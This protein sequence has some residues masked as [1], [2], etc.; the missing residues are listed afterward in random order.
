MIDVRA[1][2]VEVTG[3]RDG[4]MLDRALGALIGGAIGDAL[5][6]PTQTLS[7]AEIAASFG[8]VTGFLAPRPGHPVSHGLIAGAVTDDTEQTLLLA[9]ALLRPG[10]FDPAAW[11]QDL[12]GWEAAVKARGLHDLLG[13]S[14]KRALLALIDGAPLGEAG[15]F[16]DTN[17]A[18]MRIAP[19]GI[20]V[21]PA[22][23]GGLLDQVEA[24]ARVTHNTGAAIAA[25]AAVAAAI[26]AA[27]D[28]ADWDMAAAAA[29][30]AARAGEARGHWV[31]GASVAAR[32]ALAIERGRAGAGAAEIGALT[33][34]SVLA[35]ESVPTAFGLL[36]AARGD[37]MAAA[38]AAAG[39]GGDTDTMAAIAGAIG[40]AIA[41]AAA[42]PPGLVAGLRGIDLDEVGRLARGLLA[43]RTAP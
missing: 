27:I 10:G 2:M 26:S 7:P 41:G 6:M 39:L 30:A 35:S 21:A 28:G 25:A 19:V 42:L 24:T 8:P 38:R 15:R 11:A 13:P 18:A 33:G 17:G 20:A 36:A 40:G 12:L 9:H 29:L 32:I 43:R 14:T 1:Q 37:G 22:P 16:G 31:A 4:A 34:T 5:G 3:T 23:G